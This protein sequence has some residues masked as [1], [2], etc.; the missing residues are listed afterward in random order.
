MR[1]GIAGIEGNGL[2]GEI[3]SIFEV[4]IRVVVP[5]DHSRAGQRDRESCGRLWVLQ[6]DR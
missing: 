2:L 4:G 6:L 3:E 5:P 1:I